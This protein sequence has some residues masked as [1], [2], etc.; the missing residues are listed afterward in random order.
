MRWRDEDD[1]TKGRRAEKKALWTRSRLLSLSVP[2]K[3]QMKKQESERG[4]NRLYL[5][6]LLWSKDASGKDGGEESEEGKRE[7]ERKGKR[8]MFV[9]AKL[10]KVTEKEKKEKMLKKA[11]M[12]TK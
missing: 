9:L 2:K 1:D 4:H 10:T 12:K 8:K 11:K 6:L 3:K 7:R 5:I